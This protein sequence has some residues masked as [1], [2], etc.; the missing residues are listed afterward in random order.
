MAARLNITRSNTLLPNAPGVE[1]VRVPTTAEWLNGVALRDLK[2]HQDHA[3]CVD[4]KGNVY[5]FGQG[6]FGSTENISPKA[7]LT[8][9]VSYSRFYTFA[10]NL[11]I[12]RKDIVKL[13]L[14]PTRV[15]ALSAS[16]KVY[17]LSSRAAEQTLRVQPPSSWK[18]WLWG[19]T[20]PLVDYAEITPAQSLSR[21]E[22]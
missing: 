9:K 3:A 18:S 2:I 19:N 8:G 16:G 6:Y 17:V 1:S 5:Q 13:T 11:I 15:Y 14:S 21:G 20:E 10:V 7:T 22:K 12:T 4:A